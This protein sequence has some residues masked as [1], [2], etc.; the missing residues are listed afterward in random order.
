MITDITDLIRDALF[1]V[2]MWYFDSMRELAVLGTEFF[3]LAGVLLAVNLIIAIGIF[4]LLPKVLPKGFFP[5]DSTIDD[6]TEGT[7]GTEETQ[8]AYLVRDDDRYLTE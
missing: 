7:E 3:I 8:Q 6:E 5:G 1:V 4:V 2:I